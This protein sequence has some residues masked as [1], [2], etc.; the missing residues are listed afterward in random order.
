MIKAIETL[1]SKIEVIKGVILE[2]KDKPESMKE[3]YREI[4]KQHKNA[5]TCIKRAI[6]NSDNEER[7]LPIS[8][9]INCAFKVGENIIVFND[10]RWRKTGDLKEGND[11]YFQKAKILRLRLRY[12]KE[13]L[14]DVEFESGQISNGHFVRGIKHCL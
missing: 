12:N 9:V 4:V 1:E 8:D 10:T 5:I 14:A 3:E 11:V 6:E 7:K 2:D 13:W